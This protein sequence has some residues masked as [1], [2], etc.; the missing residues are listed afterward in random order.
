MYKNKIINRT[1]GL[2]SIRNNVF[3]NDFHIISI[4]LHTV[5]WEIF[6]NDPRGQHKRHGNILQN[7]ILRLSKIHEICENKVTQKFPGIW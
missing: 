4:Q 5:Y 6:A 2:G 1:L 7:L 3:T